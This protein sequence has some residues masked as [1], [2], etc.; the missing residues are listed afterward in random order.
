[1][2]LEELGTEAQ[3]LRALV[4]TISS[5]QETARRKEAR[6][7]T[8]LY[9]DDYYWIIQEMITVLFNEPAV[10][11][12]LVQFIP[13]IG[14]TSF[15][16]RVS[17]ELARPLYAT[18]A[19][20]RVI[21]PDDPFGS[22]LP[23]SIPAAGEDAEDRIEK[24]LKGPPPSRDQVAWNAIAE[25]MQLDARMDLIARLLVGS[26]DLFALPRYVKTRRPVVNDEGET[27][28]GAGY[29][30]LDILT[31]D[32]TTVIPQRDRPTEA[33][34]IAYDAAIDLYGRPSEFVVWDDNK[35]FRMNSD[36][37][38]IGAITPHKY[39]RIPIVEIHR[40]ARWGCY[41][42]STTG[43]DLVAAACS[44]MLMDLI[45]LKK[46]KSQ[47][48]L[49]LTY[50]G[51]LDSLVKDQVSDEESILVAGGGKGGQFSTINLES[52]PA[53]IISAKESI[54]TSVAANYGISRERLNQTTTRQDS[55]DVALHERVAELAKVLVDAELEI[56][57]LVK[58]ISREHPK[59]AGEISDDAQLIVDLGQI[60]NRVDRSTQ[61]AVRQAERSMGLRSGV[62]DVL[63]D[64]P[65]L[66]GDRKRAMALIREKMSEEA[67]I[68]QERRA[69]NI[70]ADVVTEKPGMKP[71]FNGALGP[72]VRDGQISK[73]QASQ[74]SATGTPITAG[75][76]EE[77]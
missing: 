63:E 29:I 34:G 54:E 46:V 3:Y 37:R 58:L 33:L 56:F 48:H 24:I 41:W 36:G 59:Y 16:K 71:A 12:R 51:D 74:A 49:Q 57:E 38:R 76:P 40:R 53:K 39:G 20:R 27:E 75:I 23:P 70:P 2:G 9:R 14:A 62:D 61:L 10:R 17:D 19:S 77:S 22:D 69:L 67:V 18:T 4:D 21:L 1:L 25:E 44:S 64:K 8:S 68:I 47:S 65:E 26:N 72:A 42:D 32:M 6:K 45:V 35:S 66:G 30:C 15:L 73:D 52:D 28:K 55:D 11:Q 50:V 5:P 31:P 7:R 60:H 43:N 13:L